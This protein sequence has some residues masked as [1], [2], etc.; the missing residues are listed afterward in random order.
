VLV[1][2]TPRNEL[3]SAMAWL[4]VPALVGPMIG[5]P[6][7]GFITTYMTW[8]WIFLI[9]VPI[10]ALGIWLASRFLPATDQVSDRPIDFVGF[11]LSGIAASGFVFGL[12]VISLPALPPVVGAVTIVGG[13]VSGILYVRHAR[14]VAHPLLDLALFRGTVFR[15]SIISGSIFRIG[16]GAVPFLLPL[17]FQIGFG[18]SPFQS[19]MITFVSAIGA[20]C[21][22]F[23]ARRIYEAV[24]FRMVLSVGAIL[25]SAFIAINGL[26]T[27]A[28]MPALILAILFI[29][30]FVRSVIFTGVNA[31]TFADI[32]EAEASQATAISSVAQQ[33]SIALGVA[34][35]GGILEGSTA[36][37]G[38]ALGLT[39]FHMAFF[40]VAAIS[41]LAVI[42]ALMLAR[43]AG[44][45]VSGHRVRAM[46][47]A[48]AAS[49]PIE[50]A[51]HPGE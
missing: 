1:R 40:L 7:G 44:S 21:M 39:D 8:H 13:V 19:G 36:L 4:T 28:T 25:G 23:V 47:A 5:P 45:L 42:P 32:G 15:Q 35:A 11:L 3:V 22:K 29:S 16:I 37:R 43:D 31:L 18:M 12:S 48:T 14:H 38:A 6:L 24:G 33:I 20:L 50:P 41:A 9:N 27:P 34:V 26:F 46:P 17:M 49:L 51:P 30:G 2:A 10:G